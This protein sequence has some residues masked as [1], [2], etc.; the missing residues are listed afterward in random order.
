M[1]FGL[2]REVI[3]RSISGDQQK[4]NSS[5]RVRSLKNIGRADSSSYGISP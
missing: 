2:R 3:P 5:D 1:A 4:G